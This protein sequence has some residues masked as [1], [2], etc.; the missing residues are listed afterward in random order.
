MSL[1]FDLEIWTVDSFPAF[2]AQ[3]SSFT[4][5]DFSPTDTS[6]KAFTST[7]TSSSIDGV[8]VEMVRTTPSL[9]ILF[10]FTSWFFKCCAKS[11]I[12][13]ELDFMLVP[14]PKPQDFT[15]MDAGK[16]YLES[17]FRGKGYSTKL[18]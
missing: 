6:H 12:F 15:A 10:Y 2:L 9:F 16:P 13:A 14:V 11:A 3:I 5:P 18:L 4:C 7:S 8:R 1:P 17:I